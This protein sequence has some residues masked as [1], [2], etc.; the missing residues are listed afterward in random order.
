M[1]ANETQVAGSHYRTDMQHWDLVHKM[2]LG[3]YDGQITKYVTRHRR[4]NGKQDVEKALHFAHKW[5]EVLLNPER[6][7]ILQR[8][9]DW[10]QPYNVTV[11]H[12]YVEA[13][14]AANHLG[15][16][17]SYIITY[18]CVVRGVACVDSV[19]WHLEKLIDEY[20]GTEN[21]PRFPTI[22]VIGEVEH[23]DGPTPGYVNQDR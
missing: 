16:T 22:A 8:V 21:A 11:N 7:P 23:S 6:L 4:K 18:C 9:V 19:I 2:A 14:C 1:K 3:Y 17:E 20:A 12:E 5:K 13:Y 10:I 15:Q